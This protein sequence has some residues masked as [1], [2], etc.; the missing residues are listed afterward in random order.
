MSISKVL[1]GLMLGLLV[2]ML[3][4][5]GGG[6]SAGGDANT[7][8]VPT[9]QALAI[10][11]IATYA[12]DGGTAPS[13]EV[14]TT[15]EVSGIDATNLDAANAL[16]LTL[17]Y[18]DVDTVEEIQS[19]VDRLNA[20]TTPVA[21]AQSITLDEDT[22][23]TIIFAGTDVEGDA[24]SYTITS[25][26]THGTISGNN[27]YTPNANYFGSDSFGFVANDGTVDSTE[28]T[29]NITIDPVNDSPVAIDQNISAW[30]I[31]TINFTLSGTDIENT[32]L[33]YTITKQPMHGHIQGY[34]YIPD[35]NYTG[36]DS[37]TYVAS[38]G[39]LNSEEAI[40]K[41]YIKKPFITTW[42]TDNDGN[43]TDVQIKVG[44]RPF[45]DN[46]SS[47]YYFPY[48]YNFTIDWGDGTI[49]NNI[50]SDII[51][52][53]AT[54][55]EYK[56][57]IYGTFPQPWFGHF[58]YSF[59][60]YDSYDSKKILSIE[61]WG[62]IQWKS[63]FF[64]FFRCENLTGNFNDTP[65]LSNVKNMFSMFNRATIFNGNI[66]KWDISNIV[67]IGGMFNEAPAFNQDIGDWNTSNIE[68]MNNL[69]YG[70]E[71]FNQDIGS[72]DTGKV[73]NMYKMF[74]KSI[75][76]NQDIGSWDT[77][78]V[79][80]MYKMFQYAKHF[81]QNI[82]TWNVSKV[83]SMIAMFEFA[84]TFNQDIGAWD[85]KNVTNMRYMFYHAYMFNHDLNSWE[86][87]KVTNMEAMFGFA[88]AFN[89]DISNWDVSSVTD[90]SSMFWHAS[91]FN[92]PL[93]SW[94]VSAV[95]DMGSMFSEASAFNQ[96]LS[97]WDV[98]AVTDMGY[99]FSGA[100]AF[101]Q[102]LSAW[103]VS[104][105][106]ATGTANYQK[107]M[108]NMF[109]GVTLS[110]ANYDALLLGWSALSL[111]SDVTFSGGNS[112]YS[113]TSQAARDTLTNDYN[114]TVTDGG[115]AP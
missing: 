71:S 50:S 14:Y 49:E 87:S 108:Y 4:A 96:D 68:K 67:D 12:Q 97:A 64:A 27:T 107:G 18:E 45:D 82:G 5:C 66:G 79:T 11:A 2:L 101:N 28:A 39:E 34:Q 40:I 58:I 6:S 114:W 9:A 60:H 113:A 41:I 38:D 23:K 24:L 105:V 90:M 88:Y 109:N 16:V 100:S 57:K 22:S 35:G 104:A 10:Q 29:V 13:V 102:D 26:P 53:Y 73:T 7:T 51:H 80:N 61:Q 74:R 48:H 83:T 63:M 3:S 54:S 33:S 93:D 1:K 47:P 36:E 20:N 95:T 52:N 62:D 65:N 112:Q 44:T 25:Q 21:T 42:K 111:Q 92:Q 30:S 59:S 15:A 72:W 56:I 89:H 78:K 84:E 32:P 46:V 81:N 55:G 76:F 37:F 70:A 106:K 110:T 91:A 19:L 77:G 115:V 86:T 75:A 69:F 85:T 17:V 31:K 94:D 8:T 43:T 98:S 99:M 103:D